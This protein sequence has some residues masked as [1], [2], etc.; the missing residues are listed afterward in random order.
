MN[1]MDCSPVVGTEPFAKVKRVKLGQSRRLFER[2]LQRELGR[3]RSHFLPRQLGWQ[4]DP[5]LDFVMLLRQNWPLQKLRS[6]PWVTGWL[7][8]NFRHP[9]RP[10]STLLAQPN[11]QQVHAMRQ[12]HFAKIERK[13]VELGP[14]RFF[15]LNRLKCQMHLN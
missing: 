13:I 7:R 11:R 3:Q 6:N 9:N 15:L 14:L 4:L 1:L 12:P 10:Y 8:G 2:P 5:H